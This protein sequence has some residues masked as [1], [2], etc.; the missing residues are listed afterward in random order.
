MRLRRERKRAKL[1]QVELSR[2]SGVAQ[3]TISKIEAG[4]MRSPGFETLHKL[5]YALK[6]FGRKVDAYD[7]QP[8][9]Q[10]VLVKDVRSVVAA[11]D[12]AGHDRDR[13]SDQS[14]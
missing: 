14:E 4:V 3:G 5:A 9:R 13:R 7:L 1:T 2:F 12:K 8:K 6:K 10:P 11:T